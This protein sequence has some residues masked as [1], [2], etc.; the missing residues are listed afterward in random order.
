MK[1]SVLAIPLVL[2]LA[3]MLT[4]CQIKAVSVDLDNKQVNQIEASQASQRVIN[5]GNGTITIDFDKVKKQ[6]ER[7]DAEAQYLLGLAYHD[8]SLDYEHSDRKAVEWFAKSANQGY[9]NAQFYLGVMYGSGVIGSGVYPD[10]AKEAEWL[11]KAANQGHG[12]AQVNL[13]KMYFRGEGVEQ[14]N[15][16][17]LEWLTKA[18]NEGYAQAQ[19][20]LAGLYYSGEYGVEQNTVKAVEWLIKAAN[21]DNTEAQA[22]LSSMYK[23]GEGV[24]HEKAIEWLRKSCNDG[25]QAACDFY[26]DL[27]K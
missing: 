3:T 9:A 10:Y 24:E 8:Y 1:K 20:D 17:A 26:D 18:A 11:I 14:D 16:K 4:A 5:T 22:I 27:N 15:V 25:F 23:K 21:Q 7:G 19:I 12:Q 2:S 6:A 13:S